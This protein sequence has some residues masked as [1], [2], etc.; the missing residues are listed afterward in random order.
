MIS[1]FSRI[2]NRFDQ[3]DKRLLIGW[4]SIP[5]LHVA[6]HHCAIFTQN[7]WQA[8]L[9]VTPHCSE[10]VGWLAKASEPVFLESRSEYVRN[11][12]SMSRFFHPVPRPNFLRDHDPVPRPDPRA[13]LV[14][15]W[16]L[17]LA[18]P[19]HTIDHADGDGT[20][21]AGRLIPEGLYVA[22][23]S[24]KSRIRGEIG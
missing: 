1:G 24:E 20:A 15:F 17:M 3:N 13:L 18:V 19:N 22:P 23:T 9:P 7:G 16:K 21:G 5:S 2:R 6:A 12:S 10:G 14:S 4:L 11:G 8:S